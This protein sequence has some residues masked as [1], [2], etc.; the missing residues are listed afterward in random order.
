MDILEFLPKNELGLTVFYSAN[1]DRFSIIQGEDTK[2]YIRILI[3]ENWVYPIWTSDGFNSVKSAQ[4]WLNQQEWA[5]AT[6]STIEP[7]HSTSENCTSD[8]NFAME[9]LGFEPVMDNGTA[10]IYEHHQ[11]TSNKTLSIMIWYE[12]GVASTWAWLN[13]TRIPIPL[14]SDPTSNIDK[15]IRGIES[16]LLRFNI[17]IISN[18]LITN[19]TNR[20]DVITAAISTKNLT[21]DMIR[22]KS[23]NVWAYTI[24]VKDRKSKFGDVLVQFKGAEGGP[25]D[26]YIYYDVPVLTYRRWH[27]APSKGHYFWQYIRNYF[28]YSKLTGDKRG[29]LHNA[30]N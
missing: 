9:M 8:F 19:I 6:V 21:K 5:D 28:K 16:L 17:S 30:I 20:S 29:K 22:V 11:Q 1:C 26:I 7:L 2:Y 27:S 23:S 10:M 13:N 25:G 15:I 18:S 24:N 4:H 14:L 12:Q 3:G